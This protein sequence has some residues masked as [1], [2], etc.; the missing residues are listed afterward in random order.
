MSRTSRLLNLLDELRGRR[1]PTRARVLADTLGVSVRTI[2]RDLATLQA[3]GAAIRA[4][5]AGYLL[6]PAGQFMPPALT[7][8]EA[9]AILLGLRYSESR[10]DADLAA[11]AGSARRKLIDTSSAVDQR[12]RQLI[13][14]AGPCR[15]SGN[16]ARLLDAIRA[17]RRIDVTYR[18]GMGAVTRRRLWPLAIGL[19]D[20]CEMLAAWC[21]MREGFRHFRLD[22][23]SDMATAEERLPRPHRVLLAEWRRLSGLDTD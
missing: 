13:L 8:A 2:Y 12:A 10:G 20:D 6:D 11:A 5:D 17:E 3:E 19:F 1:Q 16:R 22:R 7:A 4:G 14:V 9:E 15:A 18:D 21:E 23:I